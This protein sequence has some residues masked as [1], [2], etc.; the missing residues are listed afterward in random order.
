L[1]DFRFKKA[2]YR[3]YGGQDEYTYYDIDSPDDGELY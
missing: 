3:A 1:N 2:I